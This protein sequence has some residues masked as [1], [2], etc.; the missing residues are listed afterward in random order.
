MLM[1]LMYREELRS[2]EAATVRLHFSA[3]MKD[4]HARMWAQRE[5]I[6]T[7]ANYYADK[8]DYICL[9]EVV[10][11]DVQDAVVFPRLLMILLARGVA[12]IMT[13]NKRPELLYENGLN[14]HLYLPP[15]IA[16]LKQGCRRVDLDH[17]GLTFDFRTLKSERRGAYFTDERLFTDLWTAQVEGEEKDLNWLI[18]GSKTREIEMRIKNN[19]I[20]LNCHEIAS[21]KFSDFDH[22][23][24]GQWLKT[25]EASCFV[26]N[27][28]KF[29]RKDFSGLAK[30]F[31]KFVEVMYDLQVPLFIHAEA[32][33][34]EVFAEAQGAEDTNEKGFD[35]NEIRAGVSRVVS[36]L[37]QLYM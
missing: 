35:K 18:P 6:E 15:L 3:L 1:D 25:K 26:R 32:S 2:Q 23:A 27:V 10:I 24:L 29:S 19:G 31:G 12:M 21:E 22:V 7:I 28:P 16:L 9:D 36:R 37:N 33:P 17:A 13:S 4:V 14:R 8:Y 30:R 11:S 20:L 34:D 5:S